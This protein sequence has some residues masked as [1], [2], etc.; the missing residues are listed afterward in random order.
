VGCEVALWLAQKGKKVTI[1]EKLSKLMPNAIEHNANKELLV[2]MLT[3]NGVEQ[4][5]ETAL[6]EVVDEGVK[7]IERNLEIKFIPC[8]SVVLAVGLKANRLLQS[9]LEEKRLPYHIIGDCGKPRIIL[10]AIWDGYKVG[11]SI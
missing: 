8:H 10:N 4:R 5:A 11:N 9:H 1:I 6:A 2:D 7:V 3:F